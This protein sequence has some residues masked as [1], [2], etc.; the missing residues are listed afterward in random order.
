MRVT[1]ACSTRWSTSASR[2]STPFRA[3]DPRRRRLETPPGPFASPPGPLRVGDLA[4]AA[5]KLQDELESRLEAE[6]T[7][8][9]A[10]AMAKIDAAVDKL[11]ASAA[12]AEPAAAAA[13]AAAAA[14]RDS[15]LDFADPRRALLTPGSRIAVVGA[16]AELGAGR[17]LL[18]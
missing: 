15:E 1:S 14:S 2:P 10:E 16:E 17:C 3:T 18:L 12:A 11:R 5:S 7:S 6:L 13:A 4:D 8:V 9:K